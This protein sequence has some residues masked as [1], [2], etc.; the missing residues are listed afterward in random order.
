MKKTY[1]SVKEEVAGILI[2]L[3]AL[4]SEIRKF[5]RNALC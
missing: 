5:G 2:I 3:S 4:D 1:A